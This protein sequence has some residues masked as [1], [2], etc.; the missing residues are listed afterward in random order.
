M[1]E[2]LLQSDD[3]TTGVFLIIAFF[4]A[5]VAFSLTIEGIRIILIWGIVFISAFVFYSVHRDSISKWI[6]DFTDMSQ[7]QWEKETRIKIGSES[8]ADKAGS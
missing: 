7:T 5:G 3:I 1:Q 4:A 6:N 8:C 2:F